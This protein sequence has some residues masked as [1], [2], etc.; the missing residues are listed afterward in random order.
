MRRQVSTTQSKTA[1]HARAWP[2]FL[3]NAEV[4]MLSAAFGLIAAVVIGA[5]HLRLP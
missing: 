2:A 4:L 3:V 5:P 1:E